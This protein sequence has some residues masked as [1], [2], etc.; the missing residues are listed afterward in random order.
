MPDHVPTVPSVSCRGHRGAQSGAGALAPRDSQRWH[1]PGAGGRPCILS[2]WQQGRGQRK[3]GEK[4]E[5]KRGPGT[6]H[7]RQ[8]PPGLPQSSALQS[9]F[10]GTQPWSSIPA[11]LMDKKPISL[12][13]AGHLA[14]LM[15]SAL[16]SGSAL[17]PLFYFCP[18]ARFS[19][20]KQDFQS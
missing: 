6:S 8:D 19:Y 13:K 17:S 14:T 3:N 12:L 1:S 15:K 20:Y 11:K 9:C 7:S 10:T 5:E 2:L 16:V 4:E 18:G